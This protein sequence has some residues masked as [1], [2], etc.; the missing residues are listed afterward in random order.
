MVGGG[1]SRDPWSGIS[2]IKA[3]SSVEAPVL[4]SRAAGVPV[5]RTLPLSSATSH[6]KRAASSM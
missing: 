6:S 1:A 4:A 2:A 5:A 3:S